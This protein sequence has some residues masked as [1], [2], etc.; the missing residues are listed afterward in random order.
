MTSIF[1]VL[2]TTSVYA[3]GYRPSKERAEY[4]HN[5]SKLTAK[6]PSPG[7]YHF[8]GRLSASGLP[9]TVQDIPFVTVMT[10]EYKVFWEGRVGIN[11]VKLGDECELMKSVTRGD[12]RL[13][14]GVT[15]VSIDQLL[16]KM[17]PKFGKQISDSIE[18]PTHLAPSW[19]LSLDLSNLQAKY[20]YHRGFRKIQYGL[21]SSSKTYTVVGFHNG[22][23]FCD[24]P[25]LL[26]EENTSIEE[27]QSRAD[28]NVDYYGWLTGALAMITV[29]LGIFD[30]KML[31]SRR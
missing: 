18:I 27:I 24:R 2:F 12:A 22:H 29:G 8:T 31:S 11:G 17:F 15:F 23:A 6:F 20:L 10:N 5:S 30:Y 4:L 7:I 19:G 3:L 25:N 26:I 13:D 1:G 14:D 21:Q 16:P 9:I 28:A